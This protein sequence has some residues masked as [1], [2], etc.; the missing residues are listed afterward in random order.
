[1]VGFPASS[2][3]EKAAREEQEAGSPK[4]SIAFSPLLPTCGPLTSTAPQ[5]A[6]HPFHLC[7]QAQ[8]ESAA[9]G[10]ACSLYP[11]PIGIAAS[12]VVCSLCKT[13]EFIA[14]VIDPGVPASRHLAGSP[15]SLLLVF[16]SA[17]FS[18]HH[19]W[20]QRIGSQKGR[21][22]FQPQICQLRVR[23]TSVSPSTKWRT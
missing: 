6:A 7:S 21:G 19:L 22:R 10:A 3:E 17:F 11:G 16:S 14:Q 5:P 18:A 9:W 2:M 12:L 20:C 23:R 13:A 8:K 4:S 15:N 1:M